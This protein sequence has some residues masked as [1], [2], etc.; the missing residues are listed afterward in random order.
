MVSVR[1][2]TSIEKPGPVVKFNQ[3]QIPVLLDR[4]A[5]GFESIIEAQRNLE[6]CKQELALLPDYNLK[7]S[8]NYL[9]QGEGITRS[10]F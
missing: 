5:I 8:F 2:P 1:R 9:N 10:Q 3:D 4:L 7:D 6:Y